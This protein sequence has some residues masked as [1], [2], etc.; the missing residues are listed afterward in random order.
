MEQNV[1]LWSEK[2]QNRQ[3][4]AS[5][6]DIKVYS[7]LLMPKVFLHNVVKWEQLFLIKPDNNLIPGKFA[8]IIIQIFVVRMWVKSKII[9]YSQSFQGQFICIYN[10]RLYSNRWRGLSISH[11]TFPLMILNSCSFFLFWILLITVNLFQQLLLLW[12]F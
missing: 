6:S 3:Q 11:E 7:S 4:P 8:V 2:Y 10:L 1:V 5:H 12:Y 9:F